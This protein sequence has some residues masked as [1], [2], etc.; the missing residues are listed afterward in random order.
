M[1]KQRRLKMEK[2]IRDLT[3]F[4]DVLF[5]VVRA[6]ECIEI[7][8]LPVKG[9]DMKEGGRGDYGSKPIQCFY[10]SK[11]ELIGGF[12]K[13]IKT[14]AKG[15]GIYIGV[16]PRMKNK[17]G[18]A[19]SV[20]Y[21]GM[22]WAD[23]DAKSYKEGKRE[24]LN[25][26]KAFKLKPTII[27]DSGHG[28]HAYWRLKENKIYNAQLVRECL[29]ALANILDS[30]SGVCDISRVM[31]LPGTINNKIL[32]SPKQ[33]EIVELNQ[34]FVYYFYDF[35]KSVNQKKDTKTNP[36]VSVKE[37]NWIAKSLAELKEGRRNAEFSKLIG[38]LIK[39]N[40]SSE[41]AFAILQAH[42][43]KCK[44]STEELKN[45]I[46]SMY[47]RYVKED[48]SVNEKGKKVNYTAYFEGLVDIVEHKGKPVFLIKHEGKLVI[49]QE[50]LI[51]DTPFMP[52]PKKFIPWLLPRAEEIMKYYASDNNKR[53][54]QDLLAYHKG[55]SEL[56]SDEYYDLLVIWDFHTYLLEKFKQTPYLYFFAV[57]ERGKSRTGQGIAYVS[58]R[59][60]WTES[61]N[62]SQIIRLAN[63][64]KVTLFLDVMDLWK[65]AMSHSIRDVLLS[66]F[67]KGA[68]ISRVLYPE[69]G[70]FLDTV[71]FD[72]FGST[73][74]AT[75]VK[76]HEILETRAI[77][78]NMPESDK[79][80]GDNVEES[81]ALPL[82]ERLIAFRA[83]Y[84][85]VKLPQV[86]K[87]VKGRLG[88]ILKPLLQVIR[89][90][91]PEK[92]ATF[93]RLTEL[94]ETGRKLERS[95]SWEAELLKA[96]IK[97][98]YKVEKGMLLTK[99]VVDFVNA[100]RGERFKVSSNRVGKDLVALG[101]KKKPASSGHVAIVYDKEKIDR[102]ITRYGINITSVTSESS[103][104]STDA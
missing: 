66:R 80:F 63:N 19:D 64:C 85:D 49:T 34:D 104:K 82:K 102:L 67:E 62:E 32:E 2:Q 22:L 26:L 11:E 38:R 75:N 57:A 29:K 24:A 90:V 15:Y 50:W 31:R 83:K 20:S 14:Q 41:E 3:M 59:G 88:D 60:F 1:K 28:Y 98:E 16:C 72:V 36:Y 91:D 84:L 74:L 25:R 40:Y 52:P 39:D 7:R 81:T 96:V 45:E 92:E 27:V 6:D 30:D 43:E 5:P 35:Q 89:F 73:I 13:L 101:F 94:I 77:E 17:R 10:T 78:I 100:H 79:T 68:Q 55:I 97:F 53:L 69:K 93:T 47:R 44:F 48:D 33:V 23:L 54:Y 8:M 56:P 12:Q 37:E 9:K 61:I 70:P 71:Y 65:N 51:D 58:Y 21:I 99:E 46:D 42:A 18:D 87:P 76:M 103:D 86:K 95:T 4:L